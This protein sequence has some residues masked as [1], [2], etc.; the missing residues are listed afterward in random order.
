MISEGRRASSRSARH[1]LVPR[2]GCAVQQTGVQSTLL[3]SLQPHPSPYIAHG[4]RK[5]TMRRKT[6]VPSYGCVALLVF[7]PPDL[8]LWWGWGG[9][10]GGGAAI[11]GHQPAGLDGLVSVLHLKHAPVG[12][13]ARRVQVILLVACKGVP[14]AQ[15]PLHGGVGAKESSVKFS[16]GGGAY[17]GTDGRHLRDGIPS[18][19]VHTT[20]SNS[21]R[22]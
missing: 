17:P 20:L 5:R 22:C 11:A 16:G 19:H 13:V 12:R 3:S 14:S 10:G 9:K 7:S 2:L 21:C 4:I 18:L 8:P 15:D 1:F 6:S